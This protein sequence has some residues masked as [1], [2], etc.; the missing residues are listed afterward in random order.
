ML[1]AETT[2]CCAWPFWWISCCAIVHCLSSR[3]VRH[4]LRPWL[5][6]VGITYDCKALP[7]TWR[8]SAQ[9]GNTCWLSLR[10]NLPFV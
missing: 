2:E 10:C 3:C 1:Q 8:R 5:C 7:W 9:R 4:G 6:I